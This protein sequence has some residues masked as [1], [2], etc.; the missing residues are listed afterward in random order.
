[1]PRSLLV[2]LAALALAAAGCG[3]SDSSSSSSTGAATTAA[4]ASTGAGGA[5]RVAIRN[6]AF[7]PKAVT[8]KVGQAITWENSD[9]AAHN[10]VSESGVKIES[11][12][13]QTGDSFTFT[14]KQPGTISYVCTFHP[15]M[16]GNTI[17]VTG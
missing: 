14:P 15:Q 9:S 8:V 17:T 5:T 7:D 4:P 10:V 13:L 16:T 1:M 2:P 3:G 12:T 11:P 6:F